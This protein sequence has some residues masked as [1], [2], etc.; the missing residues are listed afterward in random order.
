MNEQHEEDQKRIQEI[1]S[2]NDKNTDYNK[3]NE[4]YNI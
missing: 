1:I 4:N 3:K 2:N